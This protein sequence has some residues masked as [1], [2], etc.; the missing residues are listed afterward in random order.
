MFEKAKKDK[1]EKTEVLNLKELSS[2]LTDVPPPITSR[3]SEDVSE[4]VEMDNE[5]EKGK[6]SRPNTR[7]NSRDRSV[8]HGEPLQKLIDSLKDDLALTST[9]DNG[10]GRIIIGNVAQLKEL[11][12]KA[13][14][15]YLDNIDRTV[16]DFNEYKDSLKQNI[17]ERIDSKLEEHNSNLDEMLNQKLLERELN[18]HDQTETIKPPT[19]YSPRDILSN[20]E[21]KVTAANNS[22]PTKRKFSGSA[23]PNQ[24]TIVEFLIN[25]NAAQRKC[26][27][28]KKEFTEYLNLCCTG[29]T[30]ET[31]SCMIDAGKTLEEIYQGLLMAYDTRLKPKDAKKALDLYRPPPGATLNSISTDIMKYGQ[32][33]CL[34]YDK[35]SQGSAYDTMCIDALIDK[36]PEAA[37]ALAENCRQELN[38]RLKKT[39]TFADLLRALAKYST[40][41]DKEFQRLKTRFRPERNSFSPTPYSKPRAI[42]SAQIYQLNKAQDMRSGF[43]DNHYRNKTYQSNN[44]S[45]RTPYRNRNQQVY[46]TSQGT[47]RENKNGNNGYN[48]NRNNYNNGGYKNNNYGGIRNLGTG[49]KEYSNNDRNRYSNDRNRYSGYG[50]NQNHRSNN[51]PRQLNKNGLP[52]ALYCQLCGRKDSHKST[53]C[54]YAIR[55]DEGNIVPMNPSQGSCGICKREYGKTLYHPEEYCPNRPVMKRLRA[56]GLLKY[57]DHATREHLATKFRTGQFQNPQ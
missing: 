14:I 8:E 54:C 49:G 15:P 25:M 29:P 3:E 30:F 16:E 22:F 24:P 55:D 46:Q 28:S 31:V 32:R 42:R 48:S 21:S 7:E 4:Y 20:S 5:R 11:S 19:V 52:G 27:L 47:Y 18:Y 13:N 38:S 45:N 37:S 17:H 23:H 41:I 56:Q 43:K 53:D 51:P 1:K 9:L 6:R 33:A 44:Q 10:L 50:G 26:N 2:K 57:P 35:S 36:L 12:S 39:P 40:S 34:T